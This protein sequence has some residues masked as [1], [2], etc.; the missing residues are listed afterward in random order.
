MIL[1]TLK[2]VRNNKGIHFDGD[3]ETE[4]DS[5]IEIIGGKKPTGW[6]YVGSHNFTVSAWGSYQEKSTS[7]TPVFS[8]SRYS[9]S[10]IIH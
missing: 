1:G 7:F 3:T 2:P 6:A 10:T 9:K 4:D 5:D 8:V